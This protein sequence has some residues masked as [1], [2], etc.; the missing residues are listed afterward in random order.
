MNWKEESERLSALINAPEIVNFTSG[1]QME[2]AHQR[3]KWGTDS[4]KGKE[5]SD[6]FWLVGYLAGKALAAH[7]GGNTD[8]ALHHTISTAAALCNWHSAILGKTN[9]RPG[10]E[11][12]REMK[13]REMP[14]SLDCKNTESC[15]GDGD[16]YCAYADIFGCRGKEDHAAEKLDRERRVIAEARRIGN[17]KRC[18]LCG[19]PDAMN[20]IAHGFGLCVSHGPRG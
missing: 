18:L 9:M 20:R 17:D 14:A 2:A 1:V 3:E 4:D 10:T 19:G 8:K 15:T 12:G 11:E 5:P 6:W 7:I 13:D 16:I